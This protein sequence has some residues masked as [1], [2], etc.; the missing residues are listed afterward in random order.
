M[1][2]MVDVD[3]FKRFNDR[4]GHVAGDQVA[5]DGGDR[6]GKVGGGGRAFRYGGEEFA[7]LFP[8]RTLDEAVEAMEAVRKAIATRGFALRAADRPRTKPETPR[9]SVAHA[10]GQGHGQCRRGG[11]EGE[12]GRPRG[13]AA[14]R[15]PR[16]LPGQGGG[17][18]PRGA[19]VG[20]TAEVW[21]DPRQATA[22]H[23]RD[24]DHHRG[25]RGVGGGWGWVVLRLG[26]AG[27][28]RLGR[29]DPPRREAW[30]ELGGHRGDLRPRPLRG[31]RGA[32]AGRAAR[33]ERPLVFTKCGLLF[34]RE[35][36][37]RPG[38]QPATRSIRR[39]CE[40]S[41]RRLKLDRIDLYQCHWPDP[42]PRSRTPGGRWSASRRTARSA[43]SGC[44]TSTWPFSSGARRSTTSTRSS[45]R[46]P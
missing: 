8:G 40:D 27:R 34:D 45:R 25:V 39:E 20:W 10:N 19:G 33:S 6:A 35:R 3:H 2:A 4:Y 21:H 24:G 9:S 5:A 28:P 31:G 22:R 23:D 17:A 41:L 38:P 42:R 32:G 14:G 37:S 18:Q 13:R 7:V 29:G 1:A 12:A 15:R 44:R 36:P 30:R 43:P 26:P 46:S 11:G 16:P